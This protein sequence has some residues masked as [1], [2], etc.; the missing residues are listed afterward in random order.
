M[1]QRKAT[2]PSG[3]YLNCCQTLLSVSLL[4]TDMHIIL[5]GSRVFLFDCFGEGICKTAGESEKLQPL[6]NPKSPDTNRALS[7]LR[8]RTIL[9][10]CKRPK[11]AACFALKQTAVALI[12]NSPN[13]PILGCR[14]SSS[15]IS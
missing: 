5:S 14:V 4:N 10:I 12:E 15:V 3:R 1:E 11:F 2:V 6:I 13:P 7:R 8:L 9:G